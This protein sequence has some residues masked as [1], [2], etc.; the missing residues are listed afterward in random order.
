MLNS[1]KNNYISNNIQFTL[2][3]KEGVIL[4]SDN[5]FVHIAQGS[6]IE[7]VH[8]FFNCY[9]PFLEYTQEEEVFNCIHLDFKEAQFTTDIKMVK[10]KEGVL[11]VIYDLSQH[12]QEYQNVAQ[13]RNES[14][15]ASELI[16]IKN[17]ELEIREAFKNKFI[18]NFSHE[19]RNP[20][21]SIASITTVLGETKLTSEQ[22]KMLQFLKEE[23]QNLKLMLEDILSISMIA[24]GKLELAHKPFNLQ[25]LLEL[26]RFTFTAKAKE[27]NLKFILEVDK[28][29]PTTVIGDRLRIFQVL[30]NLLENALKFT[31]NGEIILTVLLNQKRANRVS[32]RFS[33]LDTGI[34]IP[35]E[36]QSQIFESFSRI[37]EVSQKEGVGLGLSIVKGLLALMQT[38]IKLHSKPAKGSEFYFDLSLEFPLST[39]ND[40]LKILEP[41][42]KPKRL[43]GKKFKVL[44]VEDDESVQMML[45]KIF[46]DQNCFYVDLANDGSRVLEEVIN[47][48]YDIIVMDVVLP[49]VSGDQVTKL[50]RDFPF[51]N[52]KSTPI[53]GITAYTSEE[54]V[55]KCKKAG[56]NEL[57][58]KPFE[59]KTLL[60]SVYKVLR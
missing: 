35:K 52:I 3:S 9:Y 16:L 60:Q 44:L 4:D 24:S 43:D 46:M 57:I 55:Q 54:Y 20:L 50:I 18:Q 30:G 58:T 49:N 29:V 48:N 41:A 32:L 11:V 8:P 6:L 26:A 22:D 10:V 51:K 28:K 13:S 12:Y 25:K 36:K 2:V 56:M 5:T 1:R 39:Y 23:N 31:L 21:T 19:L 38:D 34:G 53:L 37:E 15:I 42:T 33:V 45:F 40:K 59:P 17:K 7:N 47:N 27:K 14:V